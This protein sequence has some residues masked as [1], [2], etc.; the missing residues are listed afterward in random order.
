MSPSKMR[1]QIRHNRA[2]AA[3]AGRK[4]YAFPREAMA[5]P[6]RV[7]DAAVVTL[8]YYESSEDRAYRLDKDGKRVLLP[9][10]RR[11]RTIDG[12]PVKAIARSEA[13]GY[14]DDDDEDVD[15]VTA[16]A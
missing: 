10:S 1:S 14:D 4:P 9:Y 3:A 6:K 15:V 8:E 5:T 2:R 11:I 16:A 13:L 7:H 12:V